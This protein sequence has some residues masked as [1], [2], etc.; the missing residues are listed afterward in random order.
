[1]FTGIIEEVGRLKSLRRGT[2]RIGCRLVLDGLKIGDS[3]ST[4]GICLTVTKFDGECFSANVMP[5][6]I[7]RTSLE[8]LTFGAKVNLERALRLGDRLGGHIVSGHIDGVGRIVLIRAEGNARVVEVECDRSMLRQIVEK[9]SV[10]LDGMSLTVM[11]VGS[12]SFSVS[13]IPHTMSVTNFID[14]KVGDAVNIETDVIGKYVE[15]L[16]SMSE[17]PA[18]FPSTITKDF[19]L[20]NGF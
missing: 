11:G 14:K 6:T 13:L 18:R 19:L 15:R 10:A 8:E 20:A 16:M 17:S 7:K 5:E 9:G 2:I 1:M 3:I 12:K 4:N